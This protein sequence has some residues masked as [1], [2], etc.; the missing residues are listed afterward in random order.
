MNATSRLREIDFLRGLAILLVLVRHRHMFE[1]TTNI[2][3]IGVDL[4]FTLSGFLVSGLLFKEYI[5]FGDIEPKRF[6]I[7]RGFKI[8]P[9]YYLFYLL[10]LIPIIT[11]NQFKLI[12]FLSDMVFVQN[13][14]NGFGYAFGPSWSLAVEEHFYFTLAIFLWAGIKYKFIIINTTNDINKNSISLQK[15]V[16]VLL[17]LCLLFR[18]MSNLIFPGEITRNFTMTHLRIDSLIAGVYVSYLF[19]FKKAELIQ[20]FYKYKYLFFTLASLGLAWTPF[21][22]PVPSF[23]AKTIGFTL[24]YLSFSIILIYFIVNSKINDGINRLFTKPIVDLISKIGFCSYSIYIIYSLVNFC[25]DRIHDLFKIHH[26]PVVDFI[27]TSIAS[28]LLG[29][30]M[31]FVIEN[32]FLKLRNKYFPSRY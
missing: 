13:Y 7:R 32:Y 16:F 29:L 12:P 3:W 24:I 17:S 14:V 6:L 5:K 4:F 20:V 27:L 28:V 2:G 11:Y 22:E 15:L 26:Y 23:F 10:Y 9:I 8:Y 30:F 1:F 21:L 18:I 19:H 25:S 31:T